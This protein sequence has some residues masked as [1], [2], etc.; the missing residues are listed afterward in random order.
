LKSGNYFHPGI[1]I[2]IFSKYGYKSLATIMKVNRRNI[3]S[4]GL[5]D[6]EVRDFE[7]WGTA[8]NLNLNQALKQ[9]IAYTT[10][11]KKPDKKAA[12]LQGISA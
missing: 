4:C 9:C 10:Q 5:T 12:E 8:L 11:N 2:E 6:Q 1:R 7:K 3:V